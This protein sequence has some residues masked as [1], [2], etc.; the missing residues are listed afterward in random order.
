MKPMNSTLPIQCT[1]FSTSERIS[2]DS[3]SACRSAG[4]TDARPDALRRLYISRSYRPTGPSEALARRH[5][6]CE[7]QVQRQLASFVAAGTRGPSLGRKATLASPR[8]GGPMLARS[9]R[10]SDPAGIVVGLAGREKSRTSVPVAASMTRG[11][12]MN[13]VRLP[14]G[15]AADGLKSGRVC[16]AFR[17]PVPS[18]GWSTLTTVLNQRHRLQH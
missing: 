11:N 13:L 16:K 12:Q 14:R 17:A 2:G 8:C 10:P 6:G 18:P 1:N 5:H 3:P 7:P 9:F 4:G 15:T